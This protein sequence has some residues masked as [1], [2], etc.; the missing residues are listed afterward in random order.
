MNNKRVFK[1]ALDGKDVE[2]AV[3]RPNQKVKEKAQLAFNRAF[4]QAVTPEDGKPGALVRSKVDSVMREQKLWDDAKQARYDEVYARL[5]DGEK[6]LARGGG[7]M[8]SAKAAA[9]Q[10]LKDRRELASMSRDRNDLDKVTAEAQ[11]ENARFNFLISACTVYNET[12]QP[13]YKD[14]ED[15]F[16]R[17]EDPVAEQA[18]KVLGEMIYNL[19]ENFESKLPENVFMLKYKLVDEKLRFI[20][21]DGKLTDVEGRLV[22]EEGRYVNEQGERVDRDGNRLDDEGNYL[23]DFVPFTD[24]DGNPIV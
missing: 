17:E 23:F 6:R 20:N 5:L 9:L 3:V 13:F 2:F 24:E 22:N 15:Y 4:R 7:T 12:G 19:D 8:V 1:V 14:V 18:A 10:M 16:A 11:A 21:K